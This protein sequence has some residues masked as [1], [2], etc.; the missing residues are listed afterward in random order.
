MFGFFSTNIALVKMCILLFVVVSASSAMEN[1]LSSKGLPTYKLEF[2]SMNQVRDVATPL[3]K[4]IM[5]C[6]YL[7][8][9]GILPGNIEQVS[10]V[11][12]QRLKTVLCS[13]F[14]CMEFRP[15]QLQ[16]MLSVLH[17]KDGI[18]KMGTGAGKSLCM[19]M[20]P[21]TYSDTAV[22]VIISPLKALMD[23]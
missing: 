4:G 1:L 22:G 9:N 21:L 20:V 5:N 10:C 8:R 16:A 2:L 17:G 23:N 19:F 14:G 7:F 12:L 11:A 18:V 3:V 6:Q 15:G 13:V